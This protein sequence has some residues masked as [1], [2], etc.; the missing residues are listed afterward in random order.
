MCFK[1]MRTLK[2]QHSLSEHASEIT[3][4]LECLEEIGMARK[5]MLRKSLS[6]D[7][8]SAPEFL[9]HSFQLIIFQS[10]KPFRTF[11]Q[12]LHQALSSQDIRAYI[13]D[14]NPRL[15]TIGL[16]WVEDMD[17]ILNDLVL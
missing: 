9:L 1:T 7:K 2:K 15:M 6:G 8:V 17:G 3:K 5:G 13:E 10:R 11:I 16:K 4:V 14:R 12:W